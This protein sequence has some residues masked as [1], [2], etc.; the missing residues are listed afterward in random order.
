MFAIVSGNKETM[1]RYILS[2]SRKLTNFGDIGDEFK[3]I[4]VTAETQKCHI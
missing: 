1:C 2:Y 3:K 4:V